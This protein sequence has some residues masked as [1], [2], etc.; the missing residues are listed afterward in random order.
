M[1]NETLDSFLNQ[2]LTKTELEKFSFFIA[3]LDPHP[4]PLPKGEGIPTNK[5]PGPFSL[6]DDGSGFQVL[7]PSRVQPINISSSP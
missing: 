4:N 2:H 6:R 3:S 7:M 1:T 5:K